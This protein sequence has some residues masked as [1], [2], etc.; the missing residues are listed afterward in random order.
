MSQVTTYLGPA[1]TRAMPSQGAAR[2]LAQLAL[3]AAAVALMTLAAKTKMQIGPVPIT[4]QTLVLPLIAA[5]YGSR[6]GAAAMIAYLAAGLAGAPV[7]TNT[8]PAAP[9]P[10]YFLGPTGGYLLMYPVAAF[11]IG[12]IAERKAGRNLAILFAAMLAGDA[13]IFAGGVVWL[14]F[15][16]ILS[17]G[18]PGMGLVKAWTVGA[19][20]FLFADLVKQALAAG[21][22]VGTGWISRKS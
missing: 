21:L 1:M 2:W 8:P 20:P 11:I 13:L 7:F 15:F 14:A 17:S 5:T 3:L 6:L 18:S 19:A 9:G 22:V 16:A 10:G 12:W 4:L